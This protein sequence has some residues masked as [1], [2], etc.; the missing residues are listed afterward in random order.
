MSNRTPSLATSPLIGAVRFLRIRTA[1][2]SES[3]VERPFVSSQEGPPDFVLSPKAECPFYEFEEI[4]YNAQ[5]GDANPA[6]V[7]D[8]YPRFSWSKV[9]PFIGGLR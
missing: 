7:E 3:P 6:D 1:P 2:R 8:Q 5:L 9:E 4:G